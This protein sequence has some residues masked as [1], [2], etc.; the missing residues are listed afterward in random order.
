MESSAGMEKHSL[1]L[2]INGMVKE[3]STL[4]SFV[5]EGIQT[6]EIQRVKG[7]KVLM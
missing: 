5:C 6:Y 1:E 3:L 2:D 7:I 4:Q